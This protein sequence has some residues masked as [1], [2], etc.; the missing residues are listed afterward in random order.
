MSE[1]LAMALV[2]DKFAEEMDALTGKP[3]VTEIEWKL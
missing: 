3:T 1:S 2:A